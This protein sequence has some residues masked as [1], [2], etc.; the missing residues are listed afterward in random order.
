V[1]GS[2][3]FL[4]ATPLPAGESSRSRSET[5]VS[6]LGDR[7]GADSDAR[8]GLGNPFDLADDDRGQRPVTGRTGTDDRDTHAEREDRGGPSEGSVTRDDADGF[9][10]F[11]EFADDSEPGSDRGESERYS[12]LAR[13]DERERVDASGEP[14]R[15]DPAVEQGDTADAD[16]EFGWPD[17]DDQDDCAGPPA[18]SGRPGQLREP[19][20]SPDQSDGRSLSRGAAG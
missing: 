4:P 11:D 17:F 2:S 13:C 15:D 14:E 12:E 5:S 10:G 3:G 1:E 20:S 18:P 16:D 19:R 8:R 7:P 6:S 9:D